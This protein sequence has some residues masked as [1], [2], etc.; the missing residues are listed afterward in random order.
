MVSELG[1]F[2]AQHIN[3]GH[4]EASPSCQERQ[5]QS[6]SRNPREREWNERNQECDR[7]WKCM[8][9]RELR[10]PHQPEGVASSYHGPHASGHQNGPAKPQWSFHLILQSRSTAPPPK[11]QAGEGHEKNHHHDHHVQSFT[12]F[13][14]IACWKTHLFI[15]YSWCVTGTCLRVNTSAQGISVFAVRRVHLHSTSVA[16]STFSLAELELLA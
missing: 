15:S 3:R 7:C 12:Y 11:D 2:P 10:P 6:M 14:I 13:C 4:H 9:K 5:V 8:H 16:A 1:S